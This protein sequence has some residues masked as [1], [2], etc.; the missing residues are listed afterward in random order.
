MELARCG[1]DVDE[2]ALAPLF[3]EENTG[4]AEPLFAAAASGGGGSGGMGRPAPGGPRAIVL[5]P[6]LLGV[7][8]PPLSKEE[9]HERHLD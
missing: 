7:Y 1:S 4:G 3:V 5:H 6:G 9:H 2:Q 8:A